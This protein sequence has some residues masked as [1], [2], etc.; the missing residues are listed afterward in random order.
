MD[1]GNKRLLLKELMEGQ[2]R[3]LLLEWG[4]VDEL[5]AAAAPF[6]DPKDP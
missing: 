4:S 6:L 1:L 3:A 2:W 5:G